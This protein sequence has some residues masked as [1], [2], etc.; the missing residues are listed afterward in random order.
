[1]RMCTTGAIGR[2]AAEKER[3]KLF[4]LYDPETPRP[5]PDALCE[6]GRGDDDVAFDIIPIC[7]S[8]CGVALRRCAPPPPP[9]RRAPPP[10]SGVDGDAQS[11]GNIGSDDGLSLSS[12][13]SALGV[14]MTEVEAG[15]LT[16]S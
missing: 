8:C 13:G 11:E 12:G 3:P 6:P 16:P 2:T 7:C 10:N 1:M 4:A 14:R 15:L 5:G 9:R